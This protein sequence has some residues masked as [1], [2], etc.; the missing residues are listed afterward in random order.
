MN[1]RHSKVI[2]E[3]IG[4]LG[5]QLF[6]VSAGA[7]FEEVHQKEVSISMREVDQGI[8]VH[9]VCVSRLK[10]PFITI[11]ELYSK[12]LFSVWTRRLIF[13]LDRTFGDRSYFSRKLLHLYRSN[14]TGY[15]ELLEKNFSQNRIQGY[16]QSHIYASA[17]KSRSGITPF[18]LKQES[19]WLTE[20]KRRANAEQP[21]VLH[22]RRGDYRN[23]VHDFGMLSPLY[24][25]NAVKFLRCYLPSNPI[26][27]FTDELALAQKE[28]EILK[29]K[30]V[31]W[32]SPPV[33]VIAEE[34]FVL[35]Q[36]GIAHVIS[37]STFSW[38]AAYASNTTRMVLAPKT[39][40]RNI[41]EP[42]SLIPPE[43]VRVESE[44]V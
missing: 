42:K 9:G 38:W 44:W 29:W 3:V 5:N 15:D 27:I 17:L 39:W 2:F 10:L 13:K 31:E 37:N 22:V 8:T 20:M 28:F 6:G 30:N 26:W 25:Q 34:S 24:Y 7:Y 43:W 41:E 4:G 36:Y 14:V 19:N 40:M 32:I 35:M 16:F 1:K 33:G 11:E 23:Q 12:S 21:I 18:N